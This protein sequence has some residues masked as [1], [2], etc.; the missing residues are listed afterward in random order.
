MA[1]HDGFKIGGKIWDSS[2]WSSGIRTLPTGASDAR[3]GHKRV[4]RGIELIGGLGQQKGS[5]PGVFP[6]RSH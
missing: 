3:F 4:I 2:V 6:D 1:F 5:G